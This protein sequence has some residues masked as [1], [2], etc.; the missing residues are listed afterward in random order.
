VV[1]FSYTG[2][3]QVKVSQ[4]GLGATFLTHTVDVVMKNLIWKM[5]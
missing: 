3:P 4:K 5:L 2:S 1:I